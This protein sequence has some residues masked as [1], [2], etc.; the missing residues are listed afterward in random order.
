MEKNV[1][2]KMYLLPLITVAILI[3]LVS[4]R[5]IFASDEGF[6]WNSFEDAEAAGEDYVDNGEIVVFDDE[7]SV[8]VGGVV[9]EDVL[10]ALDDDQTGVVFW[11]DSDYYGQDKIEPAPDTDHHCEIAD[12]KFVANISLDGYNLSNNDAKIKFYVGYISTEGDFYLAK[13]D[14]RILT[15][16]KAQPRIDLD[17]EDEITIYKNDTTI[18]FK[19][20][21][22]NT[23]KVTKVVYGTNRTFGN[24]IDTNDYTEAEASTEAPG[25]FLFSI[26]VTNIYSNTSYYVYAIDDDNTII[27]DKSFNIKPDKG[28]M[29][30]ADESLDNA[31]HWMDNGM[32]VMHYGSMNFSESKQAKIKL[33]LQNVNDNNN[34]CFGYVFGE[35]PDSE[36][37]IK[38]I[39]VKAERI[40]K[41]QRSGNWVSNNNPVSTE[42]IIRIPIQKVERE[43]NIHLF[44]YREIGTGK[45][46]LDQK[47]VKIIRDEFDIEKDNA[48][49][50]I[51]VN[52]QKVDNNIIK[53]SED[54]NRISFRIRTAKK[55]DALTGA[56]V[57][58]NGWEHKDVKSR[59][60]LKIY[61]D[62][63]NLLF[64]T[65]D[66]MSSENVST[67]VYDDG[68]YQ[69]GNY[70]YS[71]EFSI[72]KNNIKF[73]NDE[74]NYTVIFDRYVYG[75]NGTNLFNEVESMEF[76]ISKAE[77]K[78]VWD[79]KVLEENSN[80]I[81]L[82]KY[83][84]GSGTE[85][86]DISARVMEYK[87]N[88]R[89]AYTVDEEV[90]DAQDTELP[91]DVKLITCTVSKSGNN[92]KIRI[93]T[94]SLPKKDAEAVTCHFYLIRQKSS[95][96]VQIY[97]LGD[98]SV[99]YKGA[100]NSWGQ[101]RY[102]SDV[103]HRIDDTDTAFCKVTT[104][105]SVK[106]GKSCYEIAGF[107]YGILE[108]D[109]LIWSYE[110]LRGTEL[111]EW[112]NEE[113]VNITS[114]SLSNI[115]GSVYGTYRIRLDKIPFDNETATAYF[116]IRRKIDDGSYILLDNANKA[117]SD[118]D[119]KLM[120]ELLLKEAHDP[121][122]DNVAFTTEEK[123]DVNSFSMK[124]YYNFVVEASDLD[125]GVESITMYYTS[126]ETEA[127][128]S[129]SYEGYS[130]NEKKK[131]E[132]QVEEDKIRNNKYT[133]CIVVR[134]K[135]GRSYKAENVLAYDPKVTIEPCNANIMKGSTIDRDDDYVTASSE[136]TFRVTAINTDKEDI[137]GEN[138]TVFLQELLVYVNGE[139][140]IR[141]TYDSEDKV[142]KDYC[143][144]ALNNSLIR[145]AQDSE[146]T[147]L[148][149]VT[150][151]NGG[152]AKK[153]IKVYLDD[154]R[155][156]V[157]SIDINGTNSIVETREKKYTYITN[158][159]VEATINAEDKDSTGL[160][161]IKY[162]WSDYD[163]G[164]VSREDVTKDI[165]KHP[166]DSFVKA[167]MKESFRGYLRA[168]A[169]DMVGNC[170][171]SAVETYGIIVE[172]PDRHDA[173]NHIDIA[174]S[175]SGAKD[176]NGNPLY[177]KAATA[178]IKVADTYSGIKAV[179]WSVSAPH[180]SAAN[181]AGTLS[182]NDGVLSDGAWSKGSS[183]D[184]IV[185]SVSRSLTLD[186]NSD[187]MVLKV[188]LIDNAG[189]RSE[190]S[191]SFSIDKVKPTVSVSY[192]ND[193][194]DPEFKDYFNNNRTA[195]VVVKERNF[196]TNSANAMISNSLGN[197]GTVSQWKETRD[198]QNPDNSTYTATVTFEKDGRYLLS[199]SCNDRAGN[200]SD[201]VSTGE[202]IIDKIKPEVTV[203]FDNATGKN[204]YYSNVRTA[205]IN[206]K[207]VNFEASRLGITGINGQ[208]YNLGGW[209]RRDDTY[210]SVI[211][212]SKDGVF[213]FDVSVKDKA[214]NVGNSVHVPEFTIDL[215]KPEIDIQNVTDRS[216]N[217]GDVAPKIVFADKNIDK[218]SITVELY[219]ANRGKVD[220]KDWYTLSDDGLTI[221]FKN[222]EKI[223]ENDDLYTLRVSATDL[224][225]NV[226]KQE[227]MFS[228]NRFGSIYILGNNV[229]NV[230][231]KYV[232]KAEG[233]DITE[234]NVDTIDKKK[235]TITLSINGVPTTLKEGTDYR[236][237]AEESEGEWK[238]YK[239]IF[240]DSNFVKDG[241]Y[242]L[243]VASEDAAGNKNN[244]A[245]ADK[246]A[247]IKFGIDATA[248]I[249]EAINFE[250][251]MYYDQNGMECV[252]SVM[253]NM[254][255]DS[256]AIY[257]DDVQT[258]YTEDGEMYT[259]LI[260]ESNR[261]QS[262]K[263][264][265][266]DKAGNETLV[267]YEGILVAGN[268]FIRLFHNKMALISILG[269]S[270]LII[271]GALALTIRK[272]VKK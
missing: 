177:N 108:S 200:T 11:S 2:R 99:K 106:T 47:D 101:L 271:A 93:S 120:S 178:T 48:E 162:S 238:Q 151:G 81:L 241:S 167:T 16:K 89:V 264:V 257:V 74:A 54:D 98:Y 217:K 207:E 233:L 109:E 35:L 258:T 269:A 229:K 206:V 199:Y 125:T 105:N 31:T 235:V 129:V 161:N 77:P 186:G 142:A 121:I 242:I 92:N 50:S 218:T 12:G 135:D 91:D 122:L 66:A 14:H 160:N 182:I 131:W 138:S 117:K 240:E 155:P 118:K 144:V 201:T 38:D 130:P 75:Q 19:A 15:V 140:V 116:Y 193:Y 55:D 8:I 3:M 18:D 41:S 239:Y 214:G 42:N 111:I 82:P 157:T 185:T 96:K 59:Y 64:S 127:V 145:R 165:D 219:G 88:D 270:A 159:A 40:R 49:K 180:D 87:N 259:F 213:T 69:S 60:R 132:F 236:I 53:M 100:G 192:S 198:A 190:K 197:A 228:V 168:D 232:R 51:I 171:E 94:S 220:I 169:E 211:T 250:E 86:A 85:I 247:E 212:F 181:S 158:K 204:G 133:L 154:K 225:G 27:C 134:N 166:A 10:D 174:L 176:S 28:T 13:Q 172:L 252:V 234:I 112:A 58:I 164:G 36:D 221:L 184:N 102:E 249:V 32:L 56:Q 79:E 210:S 25:E 22:F 104:K 137:S 73:V 52:Y 244:N 230:L 57:I 245:D 195:T 163:N 68:W 262:V 147:I 76:T 216:A 30:V 243:T 123:F 115:Y 7:N 1:S 256:V 63:N 246:D 34:I 261:R 148:V 107:S 71:K 237:V 113:D 39:M 173:E 143:D 83:K 23:G 45:M 196:D 175:E 21:I 5:T 72:D 136:E 141:K 251:G 146:Y 97:E 6:E 226:T 260:P 95:S 128:D 20:V 209:T 24:T 272:I 188:E 119:V 9:D 152:S 70:N 80:V 43:N 208:D 267:V 202:F 90:L 203:T 26:D 78:L 183:E 222:I 65:W 153:D 149:K 44:L 224:A 254:L 46:I 67:T 62:D 263:V 191:V 266:K 248:P 265:A 170:L 231:D 29:T 61:D 139:E 103:I 126:D 223:K 114:F 268:F 253:D 255:I 189:N 187:D 150:N 205:T 194:A 227:I 84:E 17:K 179:N 37:E 215:I 124:K 156:A 33:N 110:K 4:S